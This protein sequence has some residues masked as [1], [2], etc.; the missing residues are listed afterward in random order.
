MHE[1]IVIPLDGSGPG[2]AAI[3]Y[4]EERLSKFSPE[5]KTEVILIRVLPAF[6]TR[7][8]FKFG[9]VGQIAFTD[10]ELVEL[11]YKSTVY[12]EKRGESLQHKGIT[13]IVETSVG[14]AAQEIVKRAEEIGADLIAMS[15]HGQ[16]GISERALG[17]VTEKVLRLGGKIPVFV[18]KAE[19]IE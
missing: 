8:D 2:E 9:T 3:P 15:T 10:D 14:D 16:G 18:V 1:K 12:L 19:E 5:V 7:V 17:R 4:I 13:V 11:K 6:L